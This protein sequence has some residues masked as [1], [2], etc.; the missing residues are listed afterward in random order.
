MS[1]ARSWLFIDSARDFGGHEVMLTHFVE[2][3][4]RQNRVV[5][6]V[7]AR[8]DTRL[9][10]LIERFAAP[11]DFATGGTSRVARVWTGCKDAL[12]CM[13]AIRA[14]KPELCIVAQGCI[15]AQPA[16]T[17]VAWLLGVPLVIYMPLVDSCT[18]M[19]FRTGKLRDW[20]TRNGY[21]NQPD[22]WITITEQQAQ[23]FAAW[24]GVTRPI[25][26]LSNTV[27]PSIERAPQHGCTP[28][29]QVPRVLVLG[30]IE[31][32]QKGL[33]LLVNYLANTPALVGQVR[34]TLAGEGSFQ[35]AIEA[36]M[37][38]CPTLRELIELQ[39]WSDTLST[40]QQTDVLLIPSRFEGVPLVML[41]AMASGVP[42][43]ASDLPGTRPY[44]GSDSLFAVGDFQR[45]FELILSLRDPTHQRAVIARNRAAFAQ[46][47]SAS[48]FAKSVTTLT[49][50]LLQLA[51]QHSARVERRRRSV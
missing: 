7:L 19:G 5:P 28:V 34:V 6:R 48:V 31:P 41:E 24:A 47:A 32:H 2:E 35:T 8:R 13:R 3:L 39:P 45:A 36:Q 30:R 16:C 21:A 25:F 27:E 37:D 51:Q 17:T 12:V 46:R 42:V 15:L 43:I 1:G 29:A 40:L 11:I 26:T 50:Q 10:Q 9:R 23:S 22:A 33:D 18:S 49:E 44:L 20:V 14:L 4:A 38:C